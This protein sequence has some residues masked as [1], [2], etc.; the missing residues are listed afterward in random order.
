MKMLTIHTGRCSTPER[1]RKRRMRKIIKHCNLR[2]GCKREQNRAA[3]R[4]G[5]GLWKFLAK[6]RHRVTSDVP[7]THIASPNI[8]IYPNMKGGSDEIQER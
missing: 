8:E 1:V 6:R 7:Y 2:Q 5:T 4:M 3:G